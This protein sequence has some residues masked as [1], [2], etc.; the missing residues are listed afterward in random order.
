MCLFAIHISTLVKF[1]YLI[2][3]YPHTQKRF[4]LFSFCLAPP[5]PPC[6]RFHSLALFSFSLCSLEIWLLMLK[7]SK[8]SAQAQAF[9]YCLCRTMNLSYLI[10]EFFVVPSFL[11]FS[12]YPMWDKYKFQWLSLVS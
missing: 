5:W 7:L 4:Q 10:W 12:L 3:F 8:L 2:I 1:F 11:Q 6:L 9:P